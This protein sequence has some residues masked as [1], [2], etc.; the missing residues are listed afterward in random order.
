MDPVRE[1]TSLSPEPTAVLATPSPTPVQTAKPEPEAIEISWEFVTDIDNE[2]Q[3]PYLDI[4][5]IENSRVPRKML[6]YSTIGD[7]YE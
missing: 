5:I 6:V 7:V 2:Y 3:L 4:Y 1:V